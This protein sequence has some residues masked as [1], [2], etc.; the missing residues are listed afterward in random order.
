MMK[1]KIATDESM[2]KIV[3]LAA[4]CSNTENQFSNQLRGPGKTRNHRSKRLEKAHLMVFCL[5]ICLLSLSVDS[6]L[7]ILPIMDLSN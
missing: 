1:V 6:F 4:G 2:H 3:G 5:C 7:I